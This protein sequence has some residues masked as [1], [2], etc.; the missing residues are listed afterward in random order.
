MIIQSSSVYGTKLTDMFLHYYRKAEKFV[1][2]SSLID[3]A[4]ID[5]CVLREARFICIRKLGECVEYTSH[6][7]VNKGRLHV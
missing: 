7:G 2:K 6:N 3:K 4:T 5:S 1:Q